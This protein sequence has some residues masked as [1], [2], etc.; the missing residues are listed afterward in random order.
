MLFQHFDWDLTHQ[1]LFL[2]I[3]PSHHMNLRP[4]LKML[5]LW[6]RTDICSCKLSAKVSLML[7]NPFPVSCLCKLNHISVSFIQISTKTTYKQL[8]PFR[9]SHG[10]LEVIPGVFGRPVNFNLTYRFLLRRSVFQDYAFLVAMMQCFF[11]VVRNKLQTI[12]IYPKGNKKKIKSSRKEYVI[13]LC[14][15][16]WAMKNVFPK[17]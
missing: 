3:L 4:A 2:Y 10:F 8:I 5:I 16:F 14:F 9:E 1:V 6:C 17:L 7:D 12:N 15:K 11:H 13:R